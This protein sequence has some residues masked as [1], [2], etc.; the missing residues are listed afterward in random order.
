VDNE[1]DAAERASVEAH[2]ASCGDC[3]RRFAEATA[4]AR[5]VITLLGALDE[6]PA[7][8]RIV[9]PA[10]ST[11]VAPEIGVDPTV[12]PI[13]SRV[14]T[15]RRVAL[16]ASVLV[17]AS[18]SYQ[19]GRR[20]DATLA[21]A[22]TEAATPLRAA[23]PPKA[24]PSVVEAMPDSYVARPAPS[25]RQKAVSGPRAEADVVADRAAESATPAAPAAVAL[26]TPAVA[27]MPGVG[28]RKMAEQAQSVERAQER[29]EPSQE[30][31]ARSDAQSASQVVVTSAGAAPAP[32]QAQAAPAAQN[33][34][35]VDQAR[36]SGA[37]MGFA[38]AAP[39]AKKAVPLAGYTAIEE[40]SL[41]SVTRRRYVSAAGTPLMLLIVQSPADAKAQRAVSAAPEFVVTTSNGRSFVRWHARGMDYE[42]QGVLAPDSLVKLATQLK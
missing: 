2:L 8:V 26:P 40:E 35:S 20:N 27:P 12:V 38:T 31:R 39:A 21:P 23:A 30:R 28:A 1:L 36:S 19:V 9:P 16:A 33:A 14:V 22:M 32:T 37:A 15:L 13:R 41:P 25:V 34:A 7:P 17:V 6:K 11:V 18:I 5:Q 10:T 24:T 4:M 3:A 29:S 42:L